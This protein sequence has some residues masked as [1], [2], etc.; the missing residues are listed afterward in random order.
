MTSPMAPSRNVV[1]AVLAVPS[2]MMGTDFVGAMMLMIPIERELGVGIGTTQWAVNAYVITFGMLLVAGGR[3]GDMFGRRR[4]L[5]LG[6]GVFFAGSVVCTVAPS[7][8]WLIGARVVQGIG[9]AATWPALLA[10]G[11]VSVKASERG[12]L[13]GF[14]LGA[15]GIGNVL[16]PL[17]A[18]AAA[19]ADN[20]RLFFLVNVVTAAC[21]AIAVVWAFP[22]EPPA[23]SDE[24]IDYAG[25]VV[26]SLALFGLLYSLNVGPDW[27]W[28]SPALLAILAVAFLAFVAFPFVE[29]RVRDPMMPVP[30]MKN[31]Q[32]VMT[33]LTQG[34][35]TPAIFTMYIY[36]PQYL[37]KT[38]GWSVFLSLVAIIPC[39]IP[40]AVGSIIVGNY[41]N[42]IGPRML[43]TVGHVLVT[44]AALTLFFLTPAWGYWMLF[45]V[46][47]VAGI[48]GSMVFGPSGAAAVNSV[49]PAKAG[50]VGGLSYMFH[51]GI[52]AVGIAAATTIISESSRAALSE[53]L[54]QAGINLSQADV[55][56]LNASSTTQAASERILAG[57]SSDA[58]A[59]VE[60]AVADAYTIGFNNAIL[61]TL[62]VAAIGI[63]ISLNLDEDKLGRVRPG[64]K[65]VGEEA[66]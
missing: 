65:P 60:R 20:W 47:V 4:L 2:F 39:F 13:M 43:M 18:G 30:M 55:T 56:L 25:M 40:T 32:L 16:S 57:L 53:R 36:V 24:R 17:F 14:V 62:I 34:I 31:R 15:I 11:A 50:L 10:L 23:K 1:I 28:S 38:L 64:S 35:I 63:V 61:M 3:L 22:K 29:A 6:L 58:A 54:H 42:S 52:A 5:I 48:G 12:L 44:L 49:P 37:H 9:A 19:A 46:L 27:G 26:L 59:Q 41:Y 51:L 8:G 7:I 21:A 33:L 45:P 66:A